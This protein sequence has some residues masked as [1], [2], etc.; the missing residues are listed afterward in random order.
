M[1]HHLL[2]ILSINALVKPILPNSFL[3]LFIVKPMEI[4]V[5]II[6]WMRKG[7][8]VIMLILN[9]YGIVGHHT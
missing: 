3:D 8:N 5:F 1:C 7:V 4:Y 2:G 6:A 9:V